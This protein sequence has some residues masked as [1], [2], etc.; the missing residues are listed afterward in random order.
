MTIEVKK[1][2]TGITI[3]LRFGPSFSV[4]DEAGEIIDTLLY[5]QDSYFNKIM[6]PRVGSHPFMSRLENPKTGDYLSVSNQDIILSINFIDAKVKADP[7]LS[8]KKKISDIKDIHSNY[9]LLLEL[10]KEY[11]VERITRL[12]YVNRYIFDKPE[13]TK[14]VINKLI[15]NTIDGVVDTQLRF[16]KKYPVAEAFAK[17]K[18]YNYHNV[19]YTLE[20]KAGSD[21]LEM[22]LDYQEIYEP[23]LE[24]TGKIDF[25]AYLEKMER[26]NRETFSNWLSMVG[27]G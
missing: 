9:V 17:K 2:I 4:C 13:L 19:I 12:G 11:S 18:I 21:N 5:S 27:E 3:G 1:Y 20:K 23:T 15:A 24:S 6:F 7:D 22:H 16:T 10:F 25:K 14:H 26:Y 8:P